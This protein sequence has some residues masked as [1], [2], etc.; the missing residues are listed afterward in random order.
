MFGDSF[1]QAANKQK[2]HFED[3][4]MEKHFVVD[5]FGQPKKTG[6]TNTNEQLHKSLNQVFSGPVAA[7]LGEAKLL[8]RIWEHNTSVM[9][10]FSPEWPKIMLP[11]AGLPLWLRINQL[12]AELNVLDKKK[13][14]TFPLGPPDS[15]LG[16]AEKFMYR[17]TEEEAQEYY[18]EGKRS[19]ADG[20]KVALAA[21]YAEMLLD[22]NQQSNLAT[23]T[24]PLPTLSLPDVSV[25]TST[26]EATTATALSSP[27]EPVAFYQG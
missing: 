11:P 4:R 25:L 23:P 15:Y 10:V 5:R 3:L 20:Q 9:Q 12:E 1:K 24:T 18:T 8:D 22:A 19:M 14:P 2:S 16:K 7:D 6:G 27:S 17:Y 26:T 13:L 21:V